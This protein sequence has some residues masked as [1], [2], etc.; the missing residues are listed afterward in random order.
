MTLSAFLKNRM[1]IPAN[2]NLLKGSAALSAEIRKTGP[3]KQRPSEKELRETKSEAG[4]SRPPTGPIKNLKI[5]F[6]EKIEMKRS[7]KTICAFALLTTL[8]LAVYASVNYDPATG[9]WSGKGDVQTVLGMNN[10]QIQIA[11]TTPGGLNFTYQSTEEFE[12]VCEW[13]TGPDRN[14]RTHTITRNRESTVNSDVMFSSRMRNQITGFEL[15]HATNPVYTG[16]KI[17]VVGES[18][19]GQGTDGEWISVTPLGVTQGGLFVNGVALPIT[20]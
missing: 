5:R 12:A 7:I 17:P 2:P 8:T 20:P 1:M 6:K 14:R 16:H 13:T 9:G 4:H 15:S 3:R 19:P 11:A 18:C 10:A